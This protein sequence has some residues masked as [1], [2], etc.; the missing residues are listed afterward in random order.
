MSANSPLRRSY[1]NGSP[2][3]VPFVNVELG[4]NLGVVLLENPKGKNVITKV[5]QLEEEAKNVFGVEVSGN[6]VFLKLVIEG[7]SIFKKSVRTTEQNYLVRIYFLLR[8]P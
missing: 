6:D 1:A 4:G 5:E 8:L 7:P 2:A 3:A